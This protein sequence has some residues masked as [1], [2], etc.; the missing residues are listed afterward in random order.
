MYC[1]DDRYANDRRANQDS[2]G[3]A[4]SHQTV[5]Y[6]VWLGIALLALILANLNLWRSRRLL[7]RLPQPIRVPE[8]GL[9]SPVA[10]DKT[11]WVRTP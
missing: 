3:V 7:N 5:G 4:V 10:A 11:S 6:G 8:R 9:V 2:L 1:T